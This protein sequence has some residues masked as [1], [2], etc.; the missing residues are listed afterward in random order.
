MQGFLVGL[1]M[2]AAAALGG[3]YYY[4]SFEVM[5]REFS[6]GAGDDYAVEEAAVCEAD[7]AAVAADDM[8]DAADDVVEEIVDEAGDMAD[9]AEGAVEEVVEDAGDMADDMADAADDSGDTE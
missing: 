8:A 2:G 3:V 9:A 1:I 4:G 5:D 7:D 6:R